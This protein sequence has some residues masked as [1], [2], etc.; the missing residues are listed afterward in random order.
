V[1]CIVGAEGEMRAQQDR[2]VVLEPFLRLGRRHRLVRVVDRI[3]LQEPGAVPFLPETFRVEGG[4]SR[5]A[6]QHLARG[7]SALETDRL[8]RA[9]PRDDQLAV[10]RFDQEEVA[11]A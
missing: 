4:S 7:G 5:E 6:H 3:K 11:R 2:D 10:A 8:G 1:L 9:R